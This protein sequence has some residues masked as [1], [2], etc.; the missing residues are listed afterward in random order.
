MDVK[1]KTAGWSL[2]RARRGSE[3]L[4]TWIERLLTMDG[5]APAWRRILDVD[6]ATTPLGLDLA[7]LPPSEHWPLLQG[8]LDALCEVLRRRAQVSTRASQHGGA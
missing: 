6:K 2:E 1:G 5:D 8:Y 7:V 4:A 3:P